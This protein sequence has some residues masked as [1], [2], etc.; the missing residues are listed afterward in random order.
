[1]KTQLL[2]MFGGRSGEYEVSLV[3]AAAVLRNIPADKY[4]ITTVGITREGKWYRFD[5][6]A[7]SIEN[8]SWTTLTD[9]LTPCAVSPDYG[10]GS[11]ILFEKDSVSRIRIDVCLPVIHGTQG[12]DGTLQGIFEIAG[13]PLAGC[14]AETCAL[15]MDKAMAKKVLRE[16]GIRCASD[17]LLTE[18]MWR[19]SRQRLTERAER[20]LRY[21]IFVKPSRSGSSVGITRVSCRDE[22][23]DA[24]AEAL[25]WDD[26][27]ILEE[28]IVGR[29]IET[30]VFVSADGEI[31]VSE[32]GE[33]DPGSDFYDYETKYKNDRASYFIPARLEA[34]VAAAVRDT[35]KRAAGLL[36]IRG[37]SRID[38]FVTEHETVYLN[39]INTMPGFTPISMYPK[40]MIHSGMTFP[41]LVDAIITEALER[42]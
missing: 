21:P 11:L 30:A 3:S 31:T 9:K 38:F 16:S 17:V 42:K 14:T 7:D 13:I 19:T 10:D 33:I 27:V 24:I 2:V 12:E 1:M 28:C 29:E 39:E 5:G 35:A 15:C 25:R 20:E 37:L 32:C 23:D 36:D 22:L 40:L 8:G 6:D 18:K 4:D 34:D 41:Q 26:K